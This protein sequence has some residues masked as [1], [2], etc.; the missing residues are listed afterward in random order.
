VW[1]DTVFIIITLIANVYFKRN[2]KR[3]AYFERIFKYRSF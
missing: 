2:F 1:C 3:N